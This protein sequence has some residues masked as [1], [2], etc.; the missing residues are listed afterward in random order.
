MTMEKWEG[1]ERGEE[2]ERE[3]E[4]EKQGFLKPFRIIIAI[5]ESFKTTLSINLPKSNLRNM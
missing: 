1:F 2:V 3:R 4:R 5:T